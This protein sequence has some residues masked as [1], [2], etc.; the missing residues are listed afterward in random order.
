VSKVVTVEQ[1]QVIEKAANASGLSY[2]QMMENAGRSIAEA[3]LDRWP[4]AAGWKV[5]V[6]AGPG[7]NG[8][9]GL[10]AGHYLAEAGAQ[11]SVY[12][13][14]ER[15]E[16][17]PNFVRMKAH[18]GLIAVAGQDQRWRV[19]N[20]LIESCDLLLDAV[21]G[22]GF[23]LPIKGSPQ[24]VLERARAGLEKRAERPIVV[25]VDCPSGLDCD[26]GEAADETLQAS[27]TVTLAA[28]K[29]GHFLFPGADFV[30]E[31]LIG[32]IGLDEDQ[33]ELKAV[34]LGL[35]DAGYAARLVPERPRQSHKGTFGTVVVAAGSVNFPGALALAG[36][37]AYRVGTGLVKLASVREIQTGLIGALPEAT[38]LI[39]PDE[40]GVIAES[41]ADILREG[42]T[43]ISALLVGPGL[44][45]ER[46]TGAFLDRLLADGNRSR[47]GIG[48]LHAADAVE[49]PPLP[50][51]VVDADGLKLLAGLE[52][53]QERLPEG[54]V[55]TPHPGEMA[56]LT[57]LPVAE[58]QSDRLA[59][60]AEYAGRWGHVVILKGAFTVVA[61]PDGR[62]A[63]VPFATP[64][65]AHAGTGD[66]LAGAV[67]GLLA[68][69]M[70]AFEAAVLAA[71]LHGRAGE[72]AAEWHQ[73][74]ASVLAGD[75]A[76]FLPL[77]IAEL[78]DVR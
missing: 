26:S 70:D 31:L 69:G 2:D 20:S 52:D 54:S 67:A 71:F 62:I 10:V 15:D 59:T 23:K 28:A 65:L 11:V 50:R 7:N 72:L 21:L 42:L 37:A 29:V 60:A 1:M 17:D 39:L 27:L 77:A 55:L 48:F 38:W 58:I 19:L 68:Q 33:P 32:A 64:A 6:L 41:A 45:T 34:K 14:R 25:A 61:A 40:T 35:A 57:G 13:T 75:V 66:V 74:T 8:G 56:A 53:W 4:E 76:D 51:C 78:A 22:T 16:S 36:S 47:E 43:R 46:T 63:L 12:L 24:E 30:G 3:V 44:G 73:T 18:E 9:D 49:E 5:L